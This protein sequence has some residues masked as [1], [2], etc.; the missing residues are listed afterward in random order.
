M[1]IVP[2]SLAADFARLGEA[3]HIIEDA[4]ASMVHVDVMDGHFV[5]DH[6]REQRAQD[7]RCCKYFYRN[8]LFQKH[9]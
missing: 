1:A 7:L 2:S 6:R 8:L 4:G 5:P 9:L 3:L